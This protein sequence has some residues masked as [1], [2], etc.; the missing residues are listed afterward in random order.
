MELEDDVTEVEFELSA[1]ARVRLRTMDGDQVLSGVPVEISDPTG[2]YDYGA[3]PS[4]AAGLCE[5]RPVHEGEHVVRVR[6]PSLW[7]VETRWMAREDERVD[8]LQLRRRGNL[9]LTLE[10]A[11]NARIA[12]A[13][14]HRESSEV[15]AS[16]ADWTARNLC[17]ASSA[18]LT[19]DAA[20]R[21]SVEG[22]PRGDYS[23]RCGQA[24]GELT[25]A[26]LGWTRIALRV[27]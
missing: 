7:P 27:E 19:T 21:L 16:V 12:H 9:E 24:S 1:D 25:V 3:F 10:N 23:W 22:L 18:S 6:T 11:G 5:S 26:P 2:T 8:V 17:R 4:D 20:G 13:Q 14:V 15:S